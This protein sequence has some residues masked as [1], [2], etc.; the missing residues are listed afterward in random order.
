MLRMTCKNR[1]LLF[2]RAL[3]RSFASAVWLCVSLLHDS[4]KRC[5]P[6]VEERRRE[7]DRWEK[8]VYNAEYEERGAGRAGVAA[9]W[10]MVPD[11]IS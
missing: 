6:P 4:E 10:K 11:H 5:G 9:T 3:V 8:S 1:G 2:A 7:S